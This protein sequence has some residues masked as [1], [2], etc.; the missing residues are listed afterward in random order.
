[1]DE[2]SDD[3]FRDR[4]ADKSGRYK[5]KFRVSMRFE[6]GNKEVAREL[7]WENT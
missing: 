4:F 1:M 3:S 6:S 7:T 5:T 2:K